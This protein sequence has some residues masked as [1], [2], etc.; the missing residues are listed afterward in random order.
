[1]KVVRCREVTWV[2]RV[3]ESKVGAGGVPCRVG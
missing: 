2:V 1:M 3:V